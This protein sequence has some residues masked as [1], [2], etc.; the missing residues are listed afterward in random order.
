MTSFKTILIT[1]GAGF[2]GSHLIRRLLKIYPNSKIIN[3]DALT[4]AGNLDNLKACEDHPNYEFIHGDS[5]N[6][7]FL[8]DLFK[9]HEFEAVVHLAAESHVDNSISNPKIFIETNVIGVYNLLD[10]AYNHWMNTNFEVK[11]NHKNSRFHQVSTDE[12]YGSITSGGFNE[13]NQYKPNSPYS[14]S[15]ASA[16]MIV[17][18]FYKTYGLNTTTS[19]CS[20]NFGKNQHQEKFIPKIIHCLLKGI[21]IPVYADGLNVRDWIYVND[22]CEAIDTIYNNSVNGKKYNVG[23]NNELSNLELIDIIYSI[24]KNKYKVKKKIK[25]VKDRFGHDKRY[26]IKTQKIERELGWKC[27]FEFQNALEK[28]INEICF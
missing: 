21:E 20:N 10:A 27:K 4:Y 17:R 19:I 12:V 6:F 8:G 7:D 13:W 24:T 9:F 15:K 2:I 22:H 18:S 3:L 28:Y 5:T 26:S 14:A 11:E 16:D 23:A 1:G 25:F